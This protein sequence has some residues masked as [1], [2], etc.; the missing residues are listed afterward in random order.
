ME[1]ED[2]VFPP[3]RLPEPTPTPAPIEPSSR[4]TAPRGVRWASTPT[5]AAAAGALV[6]AGAFGVW[7]LRRTAADLNLAVGNADAIAVRPEKGDILVAEGRELVDLSRGGRT[8]GRSPLDAPVDSMC[9]N[10]GSLWTADG[11]AASIV[12]RAEDGRTT[13]F[14]LNHVPG[15]LYVRGRYLWTADKSGGAL[16][17]FLISRSIL[18][19]MLQPLDSFELHGLAAESFTIDEAGTLW[20]V[21]AAT[22]R[23]YRLRLENGTYKRFSSAPLSPFVGPQGKLRDMTIDGDAIWILAEQGGGRAALRRIA[24]SRFDWTRS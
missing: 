15:A 24:I 10:Q 22:R 9:W 5:A 8:L 3:P 19:A 17:Q 21:D 11:R 14:S 12:E 16:H 4:T 20:L 1:E 6:A 13:V 7:A 23:L 18:G 2:E